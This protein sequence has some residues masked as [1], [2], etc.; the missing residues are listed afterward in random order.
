M[1]IHQLLPGFSYG[2]AISNHALALQRLLHSWGFASDIFALRVH[3]KLADRCRAFGD[4]EPRAGG[5]T[6][7]HYSIGSEELTSAFLASPGQRLLI[8]H[9]I[10]PPHFFSAYSDLGYRETREG[11]E[12]LGAFRG[13]VDMVLADSAYNCRELAEL[14]FHNPR[15]LPILV[16]FRRFKTTPPCPLTLRQ[17][18]DGWTNFLF[19]GRI[20]PNKRHDDVLRTFVHYNRYIDRRS[21]LFLVGPTVGMEDYCADLQ[22]LARYHRVE[23]HVVFAGHV[24]FRELVAYYTLADVFLCM[25]EHEGFCVPLLEAMYH[26]IPILA[27][28]AAAVPH[29]LGQAGVLVRQ[30]DF[31]RI[32]EMAHLLVSD[33]PLRARVVRRQRERLADFRPERVAA[34]F[35]AYIEELVGTPCGAVVP[36]PA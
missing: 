10:T 18:E 25:S 24:R 13:A 17:F 20:V 32:A 9:N 26:D 33:R 5:V 35:R 29:T 23:D 12:V 4:F 34:R 8:Y 6:I 22:Q 36:A 3:E 21:R 27:F 30:K 28:D 11:R 16:D 1:E 19:V 2:D 15:E 14:G 7:Y 31:A